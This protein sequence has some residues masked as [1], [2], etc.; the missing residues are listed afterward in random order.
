MHAKSE[1]GF[2]DVSRSIFIDFGA[3]SGFIV[4]P[5]NDKEQSK[6]QVN[7]GNDFRLNFGRFCDKMRA[8]GRNARGC[9][10]LKFSDRVGQ[11]LLR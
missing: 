11:I 9:G 1:S 7:F 8:P 4:E 5:K 2:E 10:R 6:N 3:I